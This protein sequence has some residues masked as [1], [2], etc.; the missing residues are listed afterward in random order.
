MSN[1]NSLFEFDAVSGIASLVGS[2]AA[3]VDSGG[4][5]VDPISG[6]VFASEVV[7]NG[8]Q[9]DSYLF[10]IDRTTGHATIIG[11]TGDGFIGHGGLTFVPVPEPPGMILL[12]MPHLAF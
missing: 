5:A 8:G 12:A 6:Q 2:T 10:S 3:L 9:F 7:L 4:F 11:P 1:S